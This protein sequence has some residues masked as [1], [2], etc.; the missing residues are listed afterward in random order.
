MRT[1]RLAVFLLYTSER[2]ALKCG[3]SLEN[4][5][6]ESAAGLDNL[7]MGCRFLIGDQS[8]N[9][10]KTKYWGALI[11]LGIC[12]WLLNVIPDKPLTW[13]NWALGILFVGLLTYISVMDEENERKRVRDAIHSQQK[14]PETSADKPSN[15]TLKEQSNEAAQM[16]L[17]NLKGRTDLK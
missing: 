1:S 13:L 7:E 5:R 4:G 14:Q 10:K 8:M 15:K 2:F 9:S 3:N 6:C 11:L 16:A 12:I 17:D